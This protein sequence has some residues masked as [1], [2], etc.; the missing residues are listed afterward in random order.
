ME[1]DTDLV[2]NIDD[3]EEESIQETRT[4]SID[5]INGRIDGMIDGLAAVQQAITKILMTER[6]KNIIYSDDYG[7]ELKALL[8]NP[9][10]TEA[11]M[12]TEIPELIKDALL[13]DDRILEVS[14]FNL[15]QNGSELSILFDVYTIY[16][17]MSTEA[18]I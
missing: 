9:D 10:K 14:N 3:I 4:Y 11:L 8:M 18:V 2:L 17:D 13:I 6:F 15:D 1:M 12:E 16:G 7:S 5:F